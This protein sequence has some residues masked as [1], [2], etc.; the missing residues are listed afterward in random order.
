[1]DGP[2]AR[3]PYWVKLTRVGNIFTGYVSADG[4]NWQTV[5]TATVPMN[6]NLLI[7]LAV[8]S[9]NNSVLN[10]TL[11]EHVSFSVRGLNFTLLGL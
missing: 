10:S 11:F 6:K 3:L 5:G 2:P 1:V 4:I 7:G 8:T 9:H